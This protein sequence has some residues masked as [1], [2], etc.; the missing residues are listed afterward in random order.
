M[1]EIKEQRPVIYSEPL[2]QE[3][4]RYCIGHTTIT[5]NATHGLRYTE[6]IIAGDGES[7]KRWRLIPVCAS[8]LAAKFNLL[9][10]SPRVSEVSAA[11]FVYPSSMEKSNKVKVKR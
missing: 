8:C 4:Q 10:D 7:K 2:K 9:C 1:D 11:A 5:E 6:T 3:A